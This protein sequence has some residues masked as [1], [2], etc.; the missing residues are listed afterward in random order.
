MDQQSYNLK[1]NL[2]FRMIKVKKMAKKRK[3]VTVRPNS[4]EKT[5]IDE[6]NKI[7]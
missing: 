7:I 1:E 5:M 3:F 2:K 6:I 4:F